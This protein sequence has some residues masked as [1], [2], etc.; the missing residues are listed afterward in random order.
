VVKPIGVWREK[1]LDFGELV[2]K[3]RALILQEDTLLLVL[4][5]A[6]TLKKAGHTYTSTLSLELRHGELVYVIANVASGIGSETQ[7]FL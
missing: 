1:T 6:E 4:E 5:D 3:G 7:R 2:Q